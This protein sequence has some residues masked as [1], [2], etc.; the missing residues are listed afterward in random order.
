MSLGSFSVFKSVVFALFLREI[1]TR[2]GESRLGYV[3]IILEP[4]MHIVMLLL[5][6]SFIQN[7]MMPQV[8]FPLFL[9]TG[10]IPYFLFQHIVNAL[11]GSIPANLALFS[12]KPVKPIAVYV[13]RTV[14]EVLIYG[15]IFT[16]IISF[17]WWFDLAPVSIGFPLELIGVTAIIIVF[18]VVI[19]IAL[20]LLIHKFPT[21]K[22]A[23]KIMMTLLYFLSGIM[24]PLWIVPSEYLVYLEYNPVLH[25][26]EMFRESFFSYYPIV[27]GISMSLPFWTILIVGYIAMWFYTKRESLL[28]SS[29]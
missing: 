3:W 23:V 9:I 27:E 2:F 7:R 8:P 29:T 12:Y 22:M 16:L 14:L 24:Y 10:L 19:G 17:F 25:L 1:K 4:M 6:F 11:I 21:L 26:I 28:R 5:I 18:S 13:T 15:T 20:S